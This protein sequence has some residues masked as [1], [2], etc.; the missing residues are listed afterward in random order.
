MSDTNETPQPEEK[1]FGRP[2]GTTVA[3]SLPTRLC[4][5]A[6]GKCETRSLRFELEQATS[7]TISEAKESLSGACRS[8]VSR[9]KARTDFEY[10]VE[11]GDFR[12]RNDCVVVCATITRIK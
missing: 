6:I 5:L 9:A 1:A 4:E 11:T 10:E 3:D 2:A 12:T 7:K 8:A